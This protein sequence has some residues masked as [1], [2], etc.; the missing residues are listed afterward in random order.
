MK[1]RNEKVLVAFLVLIIFGA[2]NFYGFQYLTKNQRTLQLTFA[3]LR[4]DRA[5]AQVDLQKLDVW[6]KRQTWIQQ[7]EPVLGDEG[8]TKAQL[9][10]HFLKGAR[11]HNLEILEQ[12]LNNVQPGA[13]GTRVSIGL[14]VK[15]SMQGL[16]EWLSDLQHPE[17]FYAVSQLSLKADQ[18]Q[19]SMVCTLQLARYFKT[20]P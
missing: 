20:G 11:D 15:G 10:Q 2:A 16:C 4:A 5:E 17:D 12:T 9:L 6:K 14:K 7:H 18:D 13:A 19:K 8:D 1:T 3:S